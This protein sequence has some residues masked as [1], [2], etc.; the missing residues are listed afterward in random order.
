MLEQGQVDYC[1]AKESDQGGECG[2]YITGDY[3]HTFTKIHQT[4]QL[5]GQISL[6]VNYTS[7]CI[8]LKSLI[9]FPTD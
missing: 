4:V 6:Y 8:F 9:S 1:E 3:I 5:R 7:V 2:D